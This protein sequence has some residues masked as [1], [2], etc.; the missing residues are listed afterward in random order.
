MILLESESESDT[1]KQ[2][3]Y[4]DNSFSDDNIDLLEEWDRLMDV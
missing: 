4:T 1:D 2:N 3:T